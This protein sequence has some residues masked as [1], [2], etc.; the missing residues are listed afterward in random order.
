MCGTK[1]VNTGSLLARRI[2]GEYT[3]GVD[4]REQ[5]PPK[6]VLELM[7]QRVSKR[8]D[9]LEAVRL[10]SYTIAVYELRVVLDLLHR[11]AAYIERGEGRG[12]RSPGGR[13]AAGK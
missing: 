4:I 10:S 7:A 3:Y 6:R 11:G 12:P 8:I 13:G 2:K 5:L 9:V 1:G